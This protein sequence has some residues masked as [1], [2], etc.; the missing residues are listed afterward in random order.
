VE[1]FAKAGEPTL[2]TALKIASVRRDYFLKVQNGVPSPRRISMD[3]LPAKEAEVEDI[4]WLPRLIPKAE[5]K[6]RGEMPPNLMYGCGGDRKFFKT[7][8]VEAA[9][10]LRKVWDARG[11]QAEIVAWV[12][13]MLGK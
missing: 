6:L 4:A 3:D 7:H 2:E 8:Y 12:K 10:F 11:N 5:A 9:D 1:D 13:S